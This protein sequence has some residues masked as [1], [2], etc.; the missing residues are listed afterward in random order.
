MDVPR[1]EKA[2]ALICV[3]LL[4]HSEMNSPH[5]RRRGLRLPQKAHHF[6]QNST[7]LTK[8]TQHKLCKSASHKAQTTVSTFK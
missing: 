6:C 2:G 1:K 3:P 8:K 4:N 5:Q 7:K